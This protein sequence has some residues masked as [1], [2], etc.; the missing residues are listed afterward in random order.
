MV[1]DIDTVVTARTLDTSRPRPAAGR[2]AVAAWRSAD[3]ALRAGAVTHAD[4]AVALLTMSGV[5]VWWASLRAVP[6]GAM[7]DIGLVSV[8]PATIWLGFALVGASF[9]VALRSGRTAA[10]VLSL[11]A[12]VLVFHGLGVVA[13]PEMRFH[14]AWR[15]LGIADY[16]R[17]RGAV[18][19][20][21]DAY[22][23]WPAFFAVTAFVWEATGMRNMP[24]ALAWAPV[25]YNLLYLLPIVAIG[26]RVVGDRTVVWLACW[27]FSV[28]NWIGQDYFSPQGW[29]LFIYLVVLAVLL[30]WFTPDGLMSSD[31]RRSAGRPEQAPALQPPRDPVLEDRAGTVGQR[32]ALLALVLLLV[33]TILSGH[34][35]TPFALALGVGAAVLVGWC[36][37]RTLPIVILLAA[38]LW[39]GYA[40]SAYAAGH[41]ETF[42]QLG[43]IMS[44][45]E[46]TVEQ[47]L[48][49]SPGH[50]LI[51]QLRL[52]EAPVVWVLAAVGVARLVRNGRRHLALGLA[53]LALSSFPL[54]A[55]Q[56][57]GG[58]ALMRVALFALPFMAILAA[59]GLVGPAAST[60]RRRA[61]VP[62]VVVGA[63]LVALFPLTRYGNERME[64]YTRDEV[65]GV[66]AMY[67]L[68]PA[69][70]VLTSV[71]GGLPWRSTGYADYDYRVLV[72]G[73]PVESDPDP[74]SEGTVDMATSNL[75]LLAEQ[76][77]SRMAAQPTQR[78]FLIVSRS[79]GAELDLMGP[80]PTGSQDRLL[81][82]LRASG[83]FQ[84]VFANSFTTVFELTEGEMT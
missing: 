24:A 64:F 11:V 9:V 80:F 84:L 25:A 63:L 51:V 36:R 4:L 22:Q 61:L 43:A 54:L 47:R 56:S 72:D 42:G 71:T 82:A 76:V 66:Q 48:G 60:A 68:A 59:L 33:A 58:E 67:D 34:Q 50:E 17:T 19:P 21:L 39:T 57:Y 69:G 27:L 35:L 45:F 5:L 75:A 10:I 26:R 77:A 15:H 74:G 29:Y 7:T 83:A 31:V 46:Q 16:F 30:E 37:V 49:G 44:I 6:L 38:L 1:T 3:A 12:T 32:M 62:A 70:S 2:S 14:V 53:G 28:S 40:A 52:L 18:D 73:S 79:Q 23:N 20:E 13:E 81:V 78:S 41:P 65:A 8:L 55:A